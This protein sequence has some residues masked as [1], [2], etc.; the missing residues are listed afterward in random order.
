MAKR[1]MVWLLA[2]VS[3]IL[4]GG[5]LF[6]GV[7]MTLNWD[8]SRLATTKLV[9]NEYE[10]TQQYKDISIVTNS[11]DIKVMPSADGKTRVVC[12]E[13]EN[14]KHDI[15]V[16][17]EDGEA[18]LKVWIN[19]TRAWYEH[20]AINFKKPKIEVYIPQGEYGMLYT[21]SDT[22][23]TKI[24]DVST[25]KKI[26]VVT[27][28]GDV[29]MRVYAEQKIEI[30]GST[31]DVKLQGAA[32]EEI[33]I[34]TSTGKVNVYKVNYGA[35][36]I[37]NVT[38][39]KV[40]LREITGGDRPA[41]MMQCGFLVSRG[42]TGSIQLDDVVVDGHILI[43]RSTGN[44]GFNKCDAEEIEVKTST[45]NVRGRFL[46]KKCIIAQSKTGN[47]TA[48]SYRDGNWCTITTTTGDI[49]IDVPVSFDDINE[50]D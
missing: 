24:N 18:L 2:A 41:E 36:L 40:D 15:T 33:E 20:V 6:A 44:V 46:T 16:I 8:F 38:T 23:N 26:E 27:S 29:E 14:M 13:Q 17:E 21:H 31:G 5:I 50:W 30:R 1:T 39:G 47:V 10:I 4:V 37:V 45:G 22:G 49:Y 3:L 48:P 35:S 34:G 11:A 32:A 43:E 7:M 28:T 12:Y 9:T 25:F 19:D 42:N